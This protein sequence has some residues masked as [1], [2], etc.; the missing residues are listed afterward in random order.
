MS[1]TLDST[2]RS[3]TERSDAWR[4]A[5]SG[6]DPGIPR[7]QADRDQAGGG[8]ELSCNQFQ[9]GESSGWSRGPLGTSEGRAATDHADRGAAA[10]LSWQGSHGNCRSVTA[11]SQRADERRYRT[12]PLNW[13]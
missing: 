12:A 13:V 7:R 3:S 8:V 10:T 5:D 4:N 2:G 6:V 1:M 9:D 11:S